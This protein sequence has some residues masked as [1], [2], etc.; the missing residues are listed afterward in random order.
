MK[1]YMRNIFIL[2]LLFLLMIVVNE[3]VRT[4]I[5]E[6]P[7][8]K[9]GI[10]AINSGAAI[11]SKCTWICHNETNYCKTHHVNISSGYFKYTD[12]LYFG[13]VGLRKA[14]GNYGLANIILLAIIIPFLMWYLLI[15]SLNIQ[16]E[17]TKLKKTNERII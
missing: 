9:S 6:K 2:I 1:R 11:E 10:T 13:L 8:S 5:I 17:I 15:K 16:S 4:S 3:L 12:Q 7:Y 14:T